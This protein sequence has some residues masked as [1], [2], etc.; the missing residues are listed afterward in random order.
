MCVCVCVRRV[1][2]EGV[3]LVSLCFNGVGVHHE[4]R[5]EPDKVEQRLQQREQHSYYQ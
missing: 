5:V 3:S 4:A 1:G 2:I